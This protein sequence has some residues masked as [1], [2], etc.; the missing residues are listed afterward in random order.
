MKMTGWQRLIAVV[1][2]ASLMAGAT[3]A[4]GAQQHGTV[5]P[6]VIRTK[7]GSEID[8]YLARLNAFGF[9][10]AVIVAR[11]GSV[12][13]AKGYGLANR[14]RG[15]PFNANTVFTI[16]SITKQFTGAAILKMEM[17]GALSVEDPITKFFDDVPEDKAGITVH[18]L[19]THTAGLVDSLGGDHDLRATREWVFRGAMNSKL[20]WKP[21]TRY[22]Y[23]NLG[24][25]L[26]GMII[27]KVS[28]MGYEQFLRQY[29]FA[30]AEML[31][32]GYFLPNFT[33]DEL[34]VGYRGGEAWGT[35]LDRPM[36]EDGPCWNLRANG[37]IHSTIVD[38]LRWHQALLGND[39]L[40]EEA[41]TKYFAPHAD[42]G[43]GDSFYGYGWVNFKTPRGTRLL[44]HN[45]GNM[46]FSA[47]F[48]RYVDEN[49]MF[50]LASNEADFFVDPIS[51]QIARIIFREPYTLP[52]RVITLDSKTLGGFQG[53]YVLPGGSQIE[54][55]AAD[56]WL[57]LTPAG[58]EAYSLLSS[59]RTVPL[60]KLEELN[61]RT[62]KILEESAKGG[63][64]PLVEAFGAEVS[65]DRVT[66]MAREAWSDR[67]ARLGK[68]KRVEVL[69]SAPY[70]MGMTATT[71][72]LVFERGSEVVRYGWEGERLAGI[73]PIPAPPEFRFH[74]LPSGP[75]DEPSGR[76]F[77][78]YTLEDPDHVQIGFQQD[79][80]GAITALTVRAGE[81][82]VV[83]KKK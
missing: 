42:E 17:Q 70:R 49:V 27:E 33:A 31:R 29:L 5:A 20:K 79:A 74:A 69:G 58:Q 66:A 78:R 46:I 18:H 14:E 21:G 47:D 52:P 63:Y 1:S 25:S 59:G 10:G 26:L 50:F 30:P 76:K 81:G 6:G 65:G 51:D 73:R 80:D 28:N 53:S 9:S 13:V 38:M 82:D 32:T 64:V 45:G 55:G 83:A 71:A 43:S 24:Y 35:V 67:E 41:K 61:A 8:T 3:A 57:E 7:L 68:F 22:S 19:L 39:I 15:I 23:S 40:S 37:G 12:Q 75:V 34:A 60:A 77:V 11:G 72:R 2:V 48:R 54:V 44:A 62:A 4:R 36:L 56:G 16:G